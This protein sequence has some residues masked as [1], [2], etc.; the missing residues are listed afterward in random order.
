MVAYQD[1]LNVNL[2]PLNEAVAKWRNLPGE[3]EQIRSNYNSDVRWPLVNSGWEGEAATSAF[4]SF[5]KIADQLD[6]ASG[7]AK[8][9][10]GLLDSAHEKFKK[11][12]KDLEGLRDSIQS[13][14][15]L[16]IDAHGKVTY[17]PPHPEKLSANEATVQAKSYSNITRQYTKKINAVLSDATDA[18]ELLEYALRVDSN[19]RG[20]GFSDSGFHSMKDATKGREQA[21]KDLKVITEIASTD[22]N[23]PTENLHTVNTLLARHEGDPF[24]AQKFATKL[25]AEGTMDFWAKAA[26]QTQYGGARTEA[27]T[28]L[29]K[30][31]GH[32]LGT[33]SHANSGVPALDKAQEKFNKDVIRMGP[34]RLTYTNTDTYSTEKGPYGFQVM[35]SFLRYGEYDTDFLHE[36]GNGFGEG[37]N[38]V[39]GLI[40]FEKNAVKDGSSVEELWSPDGYRPM[41]NFGEGSDHGLDPMAGYMEALG[42]NPEAAQELFHRDGWLSGETDKRDPDLNYLLNGR[43]WPNG[44]ILGNESG[45]GYDELGHALEAAAKGVPY[46]QPELGLQR[47][48]VSANVMSQVVTV[49]AEEPGFLADKPGLDDSL[50]KMGAAYIDDINHTVANFGDSSSGAEV[51]DAAFGFDSGSGHIKLTGNTA[52]GFLQEVG[53]SE[54]G[55]GILSSAQQQYSTNALLSRSG[56]SDEVEEILRANSEVHGTLDQVRADAIDQK[57]DAMKEG[58]AKEK[59]AEAEWKKAA[60]SAGIGLTAGLALGPFAGPTAG[61]AAAV[62]VPTVVD[63]GS[64]L[65]DHGLGSSIDSSVERDIREAQEKMD[66]EGVKTKESFIEEG[67]HRA[68]YTLDLYLAHNPELAHSD[69]M[70]EQKDEIEDSYGNGR[71]HA[72]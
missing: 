25:G 71:G 58:V 62:V 63:A 46:D 42:H 16:S 57:I 34:E 47:D 22:G 26:D 12:K 61:F 69:W 23:I 41:V 55:Y 5:R 54:S 68:A 39:P 33:A 32:T 19:G 56:P 27:L 36:Y 28:H 49:V 48:T 3:L 2:N 53:S 50:A 31:I 37:E 59:M 9:V 52:L 1:L 64:G 29:Q 38:H 18:D 67:K 60:V 20:K 10:H 45:R 43:E 4:E 7:E 30:S 70:R 17:D 66:S 21:L 14:E 8:D 35:S 24:F 65:V 6:E 15:N 51:R 40:E 13:D 72:K 44:G 11:C